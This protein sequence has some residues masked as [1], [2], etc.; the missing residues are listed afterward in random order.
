MRYFPFFAAVMLIACGAAQLTAGDKAELV[1]REA[2]ED[3]CIAAN[4]P[5]KAAVDACIA[6][7]RAASDARISATHDGG[8]E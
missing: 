1:R 4:M 8:A 6:S 2:A 7:V 5:S 3:A